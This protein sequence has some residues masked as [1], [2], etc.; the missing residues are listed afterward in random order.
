MAESDV[1]VGLETLKPRPEAELVVSPRQ[2]NAVLE[3]VE[4]SMDVKIAAVVASSKTNGGL[5]IRC[6]ASTDDN[7]TNG[8]ANE[9]ARDTRGGS[10]GSRLPKEKIPGAGEADACGVQDGRRENVS[11]FEA[12]DLFPK[13]QDIGA[14]RVERSGGHVAAI[15]RGVNSGEGVP[16]RKNVIDASGTEILSYGLQGAAENLR[17][18]VEILSARGW[19]W[20]QIQKRHHARGSAR[21]GC[22]AGHK[23]DRSLVQ[24]L[25]EAL[26]VGE[27]ESLVC[28]DRSAERGAEL[29]ALE[30]RSGALVEEIG[31]IEIVVAQKLKR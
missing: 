26:V 29:V 30:G 5:R 19:C 18:A 27:K 10:S 7:G 25:A 22:Q 8:M 15:V 24:V 31:G 23:C 20:P 12:E 28:P 21:A 11:F 17:N 3:G 1:F 9:E 13:I 4:I 6:G 14:I 16:L 2:G